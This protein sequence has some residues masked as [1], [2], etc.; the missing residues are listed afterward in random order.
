MREVEGSLCKVVFFL[1]RLRTFAKSGW[2]RQKNR[3][4]KVAFPT[5]SQ[6]SSEK[7]PCTKVVH[8]AVGCL[9]HRL[10]LFAPRL[11]LWPG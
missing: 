6:T 10:L 5:W 2:L 7:D 4:P 3:V 8:A 9:A 11:F 1:E